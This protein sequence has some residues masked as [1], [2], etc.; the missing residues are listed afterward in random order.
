MPKIADRWV[1]K[2]LLT[3]RREGA[4]TRSEITS[5]A[6]LD[7]ASVSRGLRFLLELG[8]ILKVGELQ[9]EGGRPREVLALNPEVGY[10][11]AVDL[12]GTRM[13][14]ALTNFVGDVRCSWEED[15]PL[16]KTLSVGR[17]AAGVEM[18]LRYLSRAQRERLLALGISCPG[19]FSRSGEV[20][21]F[22]LGWRRAPLVEEL[23]RAFHLPVY[24]EHLVRVAVL[25]ERWA[26]LARTTRNFIFLM[27]GY[28]VGVGMFNNGRMIGSREGRTG[29]LG[30]MRVDPGVSDVCRCGRKGCLEAIV[31][32]PNIVRQYLEMGGAAGSAGELR[33]TDVFDRAR[34]REPAAVA[35]VDRVSRYLGLALSYLV[36]LMNPE[37]IILGGD[38]VAAEDLLPPL[39]YKEIEASA[40]PQFV[41][42]LRI[43]VTGM[44]T[45]IG[46][47]GAAY[48][49]FERS[50]LNTH[51]LK[52]LCRPVHDSYQTEGA[53]PS[54]ITV[55]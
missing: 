8:T 26:G 32:S 54:V 27:V 20:T 19:I 39:L 50:L 25:A 2:I 33:V 43:A 16:G 15:T 21:A 45:D 4:M 35:V 52:K 55:S 29:E 5:K 47:K 46:L 23:Q 12:E 7:T 49:A 40:L 38:L 1:Q 9:S 34:Q 10:F 6:R 30:H 48:F 13:R 18:V 36:N 41:D 3:M 17:V 51:V 37:L 53:E 44:G 42:N 22:N 31:S 24:L 11:V 14:F 28:G